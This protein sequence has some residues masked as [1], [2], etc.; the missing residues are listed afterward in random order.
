MKCMWTGSTM[1]GYLMVSVQIHVNLVIW[2]TG[3]H[4]ISVQIPVCES[5]DMNDGTK[6]CLYRYLFVNLVTWMTGYQIMSIHISVCESGDMNEW[7]LMC[8]YRY[9][10]VN[11]VTWT[12]G[13][14]IISVNISVCE[15][16]DMNNGYLMC[17]SRW[18]LACEP[19]TGG[20]AAQP[21]AWKPSAEHCDDQD[22]GHACMEAQPPHQQLPQDR[23]FALSQSLVIPEVK[24]EGQKK[25]CG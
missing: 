23:Q 10:F 19:G 9:L 17:L 5:G 6:L 16:G 22:E 18:W 13:Y 24:C 25:S 7:Y 4:I 3:Y 21:S 8:L 20:T 2:M 1:I 11:L 14:Q 12:T 15:S